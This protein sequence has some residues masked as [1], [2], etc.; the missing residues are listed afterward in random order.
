[1]ARQNLAL[2]I[3]LLGEAHLLTRQA[4]RQ[5]GEV[6]LEAGKLGEAAP[7]LDRVLRELAVEFPGG[8]P[9]VLTTRLLQARLLAGRG[10]RDAACA[11]A[12]S[13]RAP[14]RAIFSPQH[15]DVLTAEELTA[16]CAPA[17]GH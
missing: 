1:M 11:M 10:E 13:L 3:R 7:P 2:R 15:P 6:L 16:G 4:R 14:L 8:H 17:R 9:E 12:D 5:L